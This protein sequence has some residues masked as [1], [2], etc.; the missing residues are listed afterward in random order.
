MT[1]NGKISFE[2][3]D[4]TYELEGCEISEEG[5]LF[6]PWKNLSPNQ[7]LGLK[8]QVTLTIK[9]TE[10]TNLVVEGQLQR[11][12]DLSQDCLNIK[13][14]W[15]PEKLNVYK[16]LEKKIGQEPK[17]RQRKLPRIE[18][19]D[20][21]KYFPKNVFLYK[22]SADAGEF[23]TLG[24]IPIISDLRDISPHGAL[25]TTENQISFKIE[26][27]EEVILV[28]EPRGAY[29]HQV[30]IRA[31]IVRTIDEFARE[32]GNRI[33]KLG[34]KFLKIHPLDLQHFKQLMTLIIEEL[35]GVKS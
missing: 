12:A 20:K 31:Q 8:T 24:G 26:I 18:G 3:E 33:R 9:D 10:T 29:N 28:I 11:E 2:I 17:R 4:Q 13:F 30:R 34:M 35:Q 19:N 32:N 16:D 6:L 5:A 7:H 27:G 14:Y 15:T 23:N 1:I 25:V 22:S 21:L